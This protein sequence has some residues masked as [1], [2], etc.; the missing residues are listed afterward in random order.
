MR[1]FRI[2]EFHHKKLNDRNRGRALHPCPEGPSFSAP[3]AKCKNSA[4]NPKMPP[5]STLAG[6]NIVLKAWFLNLYRV[7]DDRVDS[8]EAVILLWESSS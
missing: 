2:G 6:V 4:L 5:E 1:Y 7:E 3:L 8:R